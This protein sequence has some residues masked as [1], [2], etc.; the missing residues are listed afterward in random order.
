[1]RDITDIV[2]GYRECACHVWNTHFLPASPDWDERDRFADACVALFR[3]LVLLPLGRDVDLQPD[4]RQPLLPLRFVR[5]FPA[6]NAE[7]IVNREVD[8]G[9]WDWGNPMPRVEKDDMDLRFIH[10][11]DWNLLGPRDFEFVRVL[12][13]TSEK[14][15]AASGKHA[16]IRST[17]V[18][19]SYNETAD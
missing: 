18:T 14:F 1:M 8:S 19:F 16:L 2:Q 10:F 7:V 6:T 17:E 4:Y 9:Y 5:V 12:I 15:P 13:A 3:G 11:F